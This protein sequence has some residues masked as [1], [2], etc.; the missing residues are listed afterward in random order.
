VDTA[1]Y[2]FAFDHF[3]ISLYLLSLVLIHETFAKNDTFAH[4]AQQILGSMVNISSQRAAI[5]CI[6]SVS[7]IPLGREGR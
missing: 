7:G 2:C 4:I 6:S 3:I 1:G 5:V